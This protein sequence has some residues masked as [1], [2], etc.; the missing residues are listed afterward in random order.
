MSVDRPA[1]PRHF[2]SFLAFDFGARR[3]GVAV[4]NRLLRTGAAQA[5]IQAEGKARLEAAVQRVRQW[6]PDALVI[7]SPESHAPLDTARD[8]AAEL[9]VGPGD[10]L[11]ALPGNPVI[12]LLVPLVSGA[13]VL[14]AETV[15]AVDV[16]REGVTHIYV[17]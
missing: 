4:G 10:R 16:E 7:T 17:P 11:L 2:N 8:V 14:L 12:P 5:T 3:T 6:Q 9:G 13:S 15:D 1:V